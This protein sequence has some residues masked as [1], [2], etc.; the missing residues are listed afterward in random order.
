MWKF[1]LA[2]LATWRVT[3]L[4]AKED[5]PGNVIYRFRLW[6]GQSFAGNLMDCFKCMSLWVAAPAALFVSVRITES[7]VSWLAISGAACLLEGLTHE[8]VAVQSSPGSS[9]GDLNHVLWPESC[10]TDRPSGVESDNNRELQE[11]HSE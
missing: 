4:L 7:F 5:G 6:L 10:E 2:V 3:H 9:Q 11:K 1:V 8:R